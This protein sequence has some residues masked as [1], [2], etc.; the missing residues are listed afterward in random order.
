MLFKSVYKFHFLIDQGKNKTKQ[1]Q[2]GADTD[3]LT[4]AVL[5]DWFMQNTPCFCEYSHKIGSEMEWKQDPIWTQ[6]DNLGWEF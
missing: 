2:P 1:N 3:T 5:E 6:S 4:R